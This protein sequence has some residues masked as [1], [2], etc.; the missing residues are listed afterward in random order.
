[1]AANNNTVITITGAAVTSVDEISNPKGPWIVTTSN[2][3]VTVMITNAGQFYD[4]ILE[5]PA[6]FQASQPIQVA[7]FANGTEFDGEIGSDPCEILLLLTGHYLSYYTVY[8]PPSDYLF[9]PN[10]LNLMVP[11]T[12]IGTTVVDG[13]LVAATNFVAIAGSG[14]YGAQIQVE[15]GTHTVNSSQPVEVQVYGFGDQYGFGNGGAYD[16]Y[17]YFGGVVK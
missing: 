10:Y 9:D 5:G 17:G 1:M 6:V 11:Q 13:A 4:I 2:E 7:Q 8:V 16:A 14:Y 15:A 3:V 12:A